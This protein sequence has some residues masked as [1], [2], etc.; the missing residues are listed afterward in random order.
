M[1]YGTNCEECPSYCE[2]GCAH[3]GTC[4]LCADLDCQ[5]CTSYDPETCIECRAGKVTVDGICRYFGESTN[6]LIKEV[7]VTEEDDEGDFEKCI[8]S[9][10]CLSIVVICILIIFGAAVVIVV[11][12][13]RKKDVHPPGFPLPS[14]PNS[15][16]GVP[17]ESSEIR[18]DPAHFT[19]EHAGL[20]RD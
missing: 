16:S 12:C 2:Y 7:I 11:T 20:N 3:P 13:C 4:S 9:T 6:T 19:N 17:I 15:F 10:G 8:S 18:E 14:S 5:I 1:Q